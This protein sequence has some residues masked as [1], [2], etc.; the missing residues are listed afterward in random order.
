LYHKAG[1]AHSRG[2]SATLRGCGWGRLDR[3]PIEPLFPTAKQ[4]LDYYHCSEHLH[5]LAAA[6]YGKGTPKAQE[7]VDASL[8]SLFVKQKSHVIAGIKRMK[9]ASAGAVKLIQP[10]IEIIICLYFV[11]ISI[12]SIFS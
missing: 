8:V 12:Y 4:V 5:A 3:D 10:L 6:Q 11:I 2:S 9:P 7:W 1:R